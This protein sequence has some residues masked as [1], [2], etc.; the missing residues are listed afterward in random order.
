MEWV[1]IAGQIALL[2]VV[3]FVQNMCF[4]WVSRT[5]NSAD[6]EAHRLAALCSN[7]IWFAANVLIL[8]TVWPAIE[9][10]EWWWVVVAGLAYTVA[11]TAGSELMMRRMLNT[12]KGKRR[13][14]A[15][16]EDQ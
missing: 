1:H 14:G 5:R 3:A 7:S 9:S 2:V 12:E 16:K 4:T 15:R 11:T 13:V 6:P 10:G 8:S